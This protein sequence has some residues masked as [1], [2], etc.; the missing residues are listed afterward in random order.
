MHPGTVWVIIGFF[1]GL[2]PELIDWS[3]PKSAFD[4]EGQ[5]QMVENRKATL[6][7]ME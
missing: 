3:M 2:L 7:M 4:T 5:K 1:S 6:R